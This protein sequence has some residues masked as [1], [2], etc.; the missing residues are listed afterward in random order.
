MCIYI[1]I[2]IYIYICKFIC[3]CVENVYI[4]TP[5]YEKDATR[6]NFFSGV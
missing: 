2:Y 5:P 4:A 3:V 6:C 1:Y